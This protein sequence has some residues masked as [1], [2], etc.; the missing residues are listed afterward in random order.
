M[1]TTNYGGG[2][3]QIIIGGM[4]TNSGSFDVRVAGDFATASALNN[5]GSVY[6]GPGAT[7]DL[8]SSSGA[9]A[10][11]GSV[12]ID[13]GALHLVNQPSGVTDVPLGAS[14][15]IAGSFTTS[16]GSAFANLTSIE[17]IWVL[18]KGQTVNDNPIGGTLSLNQLPYPLG[19]AQGGS[20][21]LDVSTGSTLNINGNLT[22]NSID[23]SSGQVSTGRNNLPYTTASSTLS[24]TGDVSNNG[25][26]LWIGAGGAHD[27]GIVG[28]NLTNSGTVLVTS[29]S[30]LQIAGSVN[31]SGLMETTNYGGGGN[32][33]IIGGTLTNNYYATFQI[34]VAGDVATLG[35]LNNNGHFYIAPGAILDP[36]RFDNSGLIQSDGT[37]L[38][39]TG[40]PTGSGYFQFANGTLGEHIDMSAFGV[41]VV[42]NNGVVNLNGTLD[43]LLQ[44]GFNPS[45]GS[46][47]DIV[48]FTAGDLTGTFSSIQNVIFNHGTE[49]WVVIYNDAGGYVELLAQANNQTT[50]EPSSVL[51]LGTGL[52]GLSYGFRRRRSHS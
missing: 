35:G 14:Y 38:I 41:I 17:G 48:T 34:L 4:L 46:S 32:Q 7:F 18:D 26:A 42:G 19:C 20:G 40:T 23:G 30:T 25:G 45:I 2:G 51:L 21:C 16:T 37:M 10:N 50:P 33:I 12:S 39:G 43:I 13:S 28:G 5:T 9:F 52:L 29:G 31:N 36:I 47:Y 49:K 15:Y 24:V 44:S 6:V 27:E 8:T 1:E 11:T 3:N 22:M